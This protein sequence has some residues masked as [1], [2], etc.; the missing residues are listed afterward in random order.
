MHQDGQGHDHE[1]EHWHRHG[2]GQGQGRDL[3]HEDEQGL[4]VCMAIYTHMQLHPY[5]CTC[6]CIP[7]LACAKALCISM[8]ASASMVM[9]MSTHREMYEHACRLATVLAA[10]HGSGMARSDAWTRTALCNVFLERLML[11]YAWGWGALRRVTSSGVKGMG[12][13]RSE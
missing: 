6:T 13:D 8:D 11:E 5:A 4:R 10:M 3:A 7:G 9:L 2:H 12:V 1:H